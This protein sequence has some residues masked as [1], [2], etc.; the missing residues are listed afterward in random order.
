MVE[1][2]KLELRQTG[3]GSR[4]MMLKASVAFT[5]SSYQRPGGNERKCQKRKNAARTMTPATRPISHL[6]GSSNATA[7]DG[8]SLTFARDQRIRAE[9]PYS[10]MARRKP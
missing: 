6:R 8:S 2:P 4:S 5:A 10:A 9:A 3:G 7:G 1:W